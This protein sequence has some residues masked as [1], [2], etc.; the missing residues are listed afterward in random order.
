MMMLTSAP[1]LFTQ[2]RDE[3]PDAHTKSQLVV[4]SA[5]TQLCHLIQRQLELA[6]CYL[7]GKLM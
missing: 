7:V 4:P 6:I 3:I 1:K 2:R 5:C